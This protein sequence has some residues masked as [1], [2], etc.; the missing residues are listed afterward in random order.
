MLNLILSTCGTSL[1][2]NGNGRSEEE[3]RLV[4]KHSNV[5]QRDDLASEV[6]QQIEYLINDVRQKAENAPLPDI[7]ACPL[8]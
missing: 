5:K 8:N 2:T 6:V 4:T 7:A 3:R 1:L